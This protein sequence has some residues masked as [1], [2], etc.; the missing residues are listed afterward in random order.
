MPLAG[1]LEPGERNARRRHVSDKRE[2]AV[3]LGHAAAL[4]L[5]RRS[6][7]LNTTLIFLFL[8]IVCF[9]GCRY[10]PESMFE[11]A[12]ASRLPRWFTLPK[13]VSRADVTVTMYRYSDSST[14]WLLDRN[15]N[16][17]AQVE[18]VWKGQLVSGGAKMNSNGGYDRPGEEYPIYDVE[19][20]NGITEVFEYRRMEP[21]FYVTDDPEVMA[22]LGLLAR[23]RTSKP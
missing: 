6:A 18:S 9:C 20:M 1:A 14:L 11:L 21:V 15:G 8:V 22:K 19:T 7:L 17:L 13:R 3:N 10:F 4:A 16:T 23:P 5:P 2:H 12:P